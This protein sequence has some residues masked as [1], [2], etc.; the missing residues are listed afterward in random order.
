MAFK[1]IAFWLTGICVVLFIMQLFIEGFT[2]LFLLNQQSLM[3]PWRFITSIFLHGSPGHLL[4][5][6]F[7]LA[8]FGSMLEALIGG[9]RFSVVFFIT[10]IAANLVSLPFYDAALG[11]SGAIFGILG[12]LIILRPGMMV[13]VYGLPMPMFIAGILW[14]AG[15]IIG[16]FTPSNIANLAHLAGIFFGF[17]FGAVYRRY[18]PRERS[19]PEILRFDERSVR[20]WEDYYLR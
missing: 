20:N 10:G 11:A 5:N 1:G 17:L 8:L 16:V 7:A 14:V 9:K 3:Q 18:I 15:D 13:F 6:G 2:D 12:T 19:Q 4:Y